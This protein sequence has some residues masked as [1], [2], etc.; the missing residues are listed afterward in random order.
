MKVSLR[1]IQT[2]QR[3]Q[4]TFSA[5]SHLQNILDWIQGEGH[6]LYNIR[7]TTQYPRTVLF[8]GPAESKKRDNTEFPDLAVECGMQT[9]AEL[10]FDPHGQ[11]LIVE[12]DSGDEHDVT[13]D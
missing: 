3:S 10:G 5:S 11:V 6:L 4:S 8:D 9:L 7:L 13:G 12:E 1:F 2:G